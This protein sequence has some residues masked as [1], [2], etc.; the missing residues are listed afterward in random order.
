[1]GVSHCKS[2][3]GS[4]KERVANNFAPFIHRQMIRQN[5]PCEMPS[6]LGATRTGKPPSASVKNAMP[7]LSG[8]KPR[9]VAKNGTNS[10]PPDLCLSTES[11]EKAGARFT[12]S[13]APHWGLAL[14][15]SFPEPEREHQ[16]PRRPLKLAP[17]EFGREVTESQKQKIKEGMQET[18]ASVRKLQAE[19]HEPVLRTAKPSAKNCFPKSPEHS[20]HKTPGQPPRAQ[21]STKSLLPAFQVKQ[22]AAPLTRDRPL[23]H[24]APS[25]ELH[26]GAPGRVVEQSRQ[27]SVARPD[28]SLRYQ[29]LRRA[30]GVDEDQ[31]KPETPTAE[32]DGKLPARNAMGGRAETVLKEAGWTLGRSRK[33]SHKTE[34]KPRKA[35]LDK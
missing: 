35:T 14:G 11:R 15:D 27:E 33:P 13:K 29:R 3:S 30:K 31:N 12:V 10:N 4:Q 26:T 18:T 34:I 1:M 9:M 32:D 8:R 5:Q 28:A 2:T 6:K 22:H 24:V 19:E 16:P 23:P 20:S 17:L 25:P 21:K 7:R